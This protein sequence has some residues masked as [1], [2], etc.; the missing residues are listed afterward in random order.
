ME[1]D[2]LVE[3]SVLCLGLYR[4]SCLSETK[5]SGRINPSETQN[6]RLVW[7]VPIRGCDNQLLDTSYLGRC[8]VRRK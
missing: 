7:F 4:D 6:F 3:H 2:I 1:M 8:N 5:A